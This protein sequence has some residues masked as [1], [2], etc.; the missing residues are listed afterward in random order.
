[1]ADI[2]SHPA[3]GRRLFQTPAKTGSRDAAVLGFSP[4]ISETKTTWYAN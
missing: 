2:S 4:T 3:N 1:M